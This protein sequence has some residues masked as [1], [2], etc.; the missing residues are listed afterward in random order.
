MRSLLRVARATCAV[1]CSDLAC[2]SQ[3]MSLGAAAGAEPPL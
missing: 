2:W 3:G 1:E